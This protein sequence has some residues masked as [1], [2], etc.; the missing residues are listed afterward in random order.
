MIVSLEYLAR[1]DPSDMEIYVNSLKQLPP[2]FLNVQLPLISIPRLDVQVSTLFA[3]FGILQ[4]Q[5]LVNLV[6][7]LLLNTSTSHPDIMVMELSQ[8]FGSKTR[9]FS[10][11]C[12]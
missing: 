12:A 1:M 10:R 5:D 2:T 9:V 8:F 11:L 7:S 3:K 4:D 6:I